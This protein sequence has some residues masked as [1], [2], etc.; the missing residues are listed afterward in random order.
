M[1][2]RD[3]S[4]TQCTR[5]TPLLPQA[6]RQQLQEMAHDLQR[7]SEKNEDKKKQLVLLQQEKIVDLERR[8]V[9]SM[10]VPVCM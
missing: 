2:K 8:K 10:R 5:E 9:S 3:T 7:I 1:H 6:Q 4:I